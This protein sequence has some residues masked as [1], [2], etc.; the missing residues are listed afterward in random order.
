VCV[1]VHAVPLQHINAV[2]TFQ[3]HHVLGGC[4][5][6]DYHRARLTANAT[7][8]VHQYSLVVELLG[9]VSDVRRPVL[10]LSHV[11][12][13][14]TLEHTLITYQPYRHTDVS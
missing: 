14:G 8:A 12:C 11:R 2:Q 10:E 4:Q 3:L 6:F 1:C 7:S 5:L 13:Y 9:M